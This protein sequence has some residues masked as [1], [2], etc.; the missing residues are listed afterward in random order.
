[1]ASPAALFTVGVLDN[2]DHNPSSATSKESFLHQSFQFPTMC[3]EGIPQALVNIPST[4][5]K[6]KKLPDS[7]TVVLAIVLKRK[8]FPF[9]ILHNY[10]LVHILVEACHGNF[11]Q[12]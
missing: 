5:K 1:M 4:T 9:P 10:C 12:G 3:N 7:Y 11:R 8:V 6:L 2:I